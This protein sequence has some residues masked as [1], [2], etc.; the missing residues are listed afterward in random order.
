MPSTTPTTTITSGNSLQIPG[1]LSLADGTDVPL[2]LLAFGGRFWDFMV[3][4][5][6]WWVVRA[7]PLFGAQLLL[8]LCYTAAR[9]RQAQVGS[10][11]DECI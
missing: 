5:M 8:L 9:G 3:A 10:R 11:V 2:L 4:G 6:A 1:P 7:T